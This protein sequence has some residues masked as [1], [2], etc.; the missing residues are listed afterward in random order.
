MLVVAAL[1]EVCC[2]FLEGETSCGISKDWALFTPRSFIRS[3][4][5]VKSGA[6][7]SIVWSGDLLYQTLPRS[8]FWTPHWHWIRTSGDR[9]PG[10][11]KSPEGTEVWLLVCNPYTPSDGARSLCARGRGMEALMLW[12]KTQKWFSVSG[13]GVPGLLRGYPRLHCATPQAGG[14]QGGLGFMKDCIGGKLRDLGVT[15][16]PHAKHDIRGEEHSGGISGTHPE[17][18]HS[19]HSGTSTSGDPGIR[20]NN[21]DGSNC[22]L[23]ISCLGLK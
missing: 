11:S 1:E 6:H 2:L 4:P 7:L 12:G 19:V 22:A 15:W 18:Q 3:F 17:C 8:L 14:L 13:V 20:K 21:S 9:T 10:S 16:K 23:K 5:K